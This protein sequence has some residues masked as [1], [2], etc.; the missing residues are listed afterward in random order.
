[1][2]LNEFQEQILE[3]YKNPKNFGIPKWSPTTLHKSENISCGD[4]IQMFLLIEKGIIIKISFIGQ[5]C[6][7]CIASAS[8]LTERMKGMTI[9]FAKNYNKEDLKE[10]LGIPLTSSREICA[11]I[12]L[13]AVKNALKS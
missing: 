2:S 7:I 12:S 13:D 8:L 1:M 9:E 6:S 4:E 3:N 10:L 5:G 11:S